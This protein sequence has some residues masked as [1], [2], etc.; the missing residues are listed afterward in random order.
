MPAGA[1]YVGR[2]T[3]FGNPF[4][5]AK[6][7]IVTVE[8]FRCLLIERHRNPEWL[9]RWPYPGD[10]EIRAALAGRDLVCWCP[11]PTRTD[12]EAAAWLGRPVD[13]PIDL[14]HADVLLRVANG[15]Q[16]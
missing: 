14:C 12:V 5:V 16:P 10:A 9:T 2:P 11:L 6:Y 8:Q 7:G 13:E 1:V 15:G 4:T 3:R